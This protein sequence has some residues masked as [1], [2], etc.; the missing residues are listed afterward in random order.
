MYSHFDNASTIA[1]IDVKADRV[2]GISRQ[3]YAQPDLPSRL[4]TL[5]NAIANAAPEVKAALAQDAERK[6]PAKAEFSANNRQK[7]NLK[8]HCAIHAVNAP[9]ICVWLQPMSLNRMHC[10]PLLI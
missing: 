4:I 9:I 10:G 6:Q 8:P 3:S 5:A 2:L 1:F 7:P